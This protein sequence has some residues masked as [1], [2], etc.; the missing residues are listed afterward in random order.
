[1][2]GWPTVGSFSL[3]GS[4]GVLI[5]FRYFLGRFSELSLFALGLQAE[6]E[7]VLEGA[8]SDGVQNGV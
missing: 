1:M 3:R 5:G 7:F 2:D 8:G 6:F 4:A